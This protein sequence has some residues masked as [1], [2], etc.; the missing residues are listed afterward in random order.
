MSRDRE[1]C[2]DRNFSEVAITLFFVVVLQQKSV[3]EKKDARGP[4]VDDFCCVIY[5]VCMCVFVSYC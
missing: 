1:K 3:I 4:S 2:K 5:S